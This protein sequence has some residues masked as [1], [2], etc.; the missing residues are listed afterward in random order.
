MLL[1]LMKISSVDAAVSPS[2]VKINENQNHQNLAHFLCV[3]ALL[4]LF[5]CVSEEGLKKERWP[6]NGWALFVALC[7]FSIPQ[8]QLL[9]NAGL[10]WSS[11]HLSRNSPLTS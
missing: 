8:P 6:L 4:C 10:P 2:K 5:V 11:R 1:L 9:P 3:F 7:V